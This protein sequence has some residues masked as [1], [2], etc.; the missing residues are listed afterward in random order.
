MQNY[1]SPPSRDPALLS[2]VEAARRL[3]VSRSTIYSLLRDQE[4]ERVKIGRA[5]RI[6][7]ASVDAFVQRL[8]NAS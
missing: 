6:S 2:I 1:Q 5:A 3:G 7:S 4:L 8:R